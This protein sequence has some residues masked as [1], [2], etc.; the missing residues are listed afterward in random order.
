MHPIIQQQ[1]AYKSNLRYKNR[2]RV[3][4][5]DFCGKQSGQISLT[6][7]TTKKKKLIHKKI[8]SLRVPT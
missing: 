5:H 6:N 8:L 2:F 3:N 4:K 1:R 7:K